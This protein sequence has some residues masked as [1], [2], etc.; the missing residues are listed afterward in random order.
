[1]L[2]ECYEAC[3]TE[4]KAWSEDAHDEHTV[5]TYMKENAAVV[6]G[7]AA[8]AL[9]GMKGDLETE[10]YEDALNHMSDALSKKINECK[11]SEATQAAGP[12]ENV[13][14]NSGE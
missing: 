5:E 11:E 13:K 9:E 1:M 10:A 3:K 6:A 8:Q 2:K 4:A 12:D 14:L 7:L